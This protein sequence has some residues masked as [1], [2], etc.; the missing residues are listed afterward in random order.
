M[1]QIK[2]PKG[3]TYRQIGGFGPTTR[4]NALA[5]AKQAGFVGHSQPSK[6]W[7]QSPTTPDANLQ[8]VIRLLK[9][10]NISFT[11]MS[12]TS[13][14]QAGFGVYYLYGDK[15]IMEHTSDP[16]SKIERNGVLVQLPHVH[17]EVVPYAELA[18]G[19]LPMADRTRP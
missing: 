19:T 12:K 4:E 3:V 11:T 14:A 6:V 1:P 8:A 10:D 13:D 18:N 9:A 2:T 5:A 17:V 15:V 7:V 16:E